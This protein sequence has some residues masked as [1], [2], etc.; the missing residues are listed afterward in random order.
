MVEKREDVVHMLFV[1]GEGM[2]EL[3]LTTSDGE[4]HK[5]EPFPASG[6]EGFSKL[7][8]VLFRI[9]AM[10]YRATRTPYSKVHERRYSL[11]VAPL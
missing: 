6:T 2:W 1:E 9:E 4:D 3:T 8:Q 10:G 7:Q 11:D 5:G